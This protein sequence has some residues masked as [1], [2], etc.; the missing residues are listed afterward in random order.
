MHHAGSLMHPTHH[1]EI[2]LMMIYEFMTILY[3]HKELG[4]LVGNSYAGSSVIV[5]FLGQLTMAA[6]LGREMQ[7]IEPPLLCHHDG[8]YFHSAD[9]P[10]ESFGDISVLQCAQQE[11]KALSKDVLPLA[12]EELRVS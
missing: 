8:E 5:V 3:T 9:V 2:C 7:S 10:I 4:D 12:N 6:G 11:A 1:E